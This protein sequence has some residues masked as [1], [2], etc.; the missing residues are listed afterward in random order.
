MS[1]DVMDFGTAVPKME[2][3]GPWCFMEV[4]TG[5]TSYTSYTHDTAQ[6][7]FVIGWSNNCIAGI[8]SFDWFWI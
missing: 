2:F 3:E 4:K 1:V 6:W 5:F 8:V 7:L